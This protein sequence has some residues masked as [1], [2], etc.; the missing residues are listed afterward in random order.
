VSRILDLKGLKCPLP[1]MMT[2]KAL[3]ELKD[4]K[5]ITVITT[6]PLAQIDIPHTCLQEGAVIISQIMYGDVTQF[7]ICH[8]SRSV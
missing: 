8:E 5:S 4:G 2:Q 3:R 7:V 1:A 6:D